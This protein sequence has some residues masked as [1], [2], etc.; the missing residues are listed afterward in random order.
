MEKFIL[1]PDCFLNGITRKTVI[2]LAK[3]QNIK[4]RE[5]Y[6]D[7]IKNADEIFLTLL[8]KSHQLK[9]MIKHLM[10]V[11]LREIYLRVVYAAVDPNYAGD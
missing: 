5:I 11:K 8:L 10:L 4:E 9:N 7:E 3:S 2:D 6:P 1:I